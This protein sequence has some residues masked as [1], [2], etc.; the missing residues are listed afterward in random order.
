MVIFFFGGGGHYRI[1]LYFCFSCNGEKQHKEEDCHMSIMVVCVTV[2]WSEKSKRRRTTGT[3]RMRHLKVV[4]RRFRSVVF[5]LHP[6]V[7]G[8]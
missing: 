2:N 7:K 6:L 4:F 8:N 5:V 1:V 3:G